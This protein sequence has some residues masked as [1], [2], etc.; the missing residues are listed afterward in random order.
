MS[1]FNTDSK[2]HSINKNLS[3]LK[4]TESALFACFVIGILYCI[5]VPLSGLIVCLCHCCRSKYRDG[6]K[7]SWLSVVWRVGTGIFGLVVLVAGIFVF[8]GNAYTDDA[9][10]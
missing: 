4:K 6:K 8:L 10:R 5:L 9:I 1:K 7:S 3:C 2:C